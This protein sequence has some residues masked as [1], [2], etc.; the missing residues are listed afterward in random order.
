MKLVCLDSMYF[1]WGLL[2]KSSPSQSD[3]IEQAEEFLKSLDDD[4]AT[5]IVPT[6]LLQELLMDCDPSERTA[7]ITQLKSRFVLAPFDAASAQI[8]AKIW[9]EKKRAKVI[10]QIRSSGDSMRTKIKI[11]IQIIAVACSQNA[12]VLY[13]NDANLAKMAEDY[14]VTRD[15]PVFRKQLELLD[16]TPSNPQAVAP[17]P[18]IEMRRRRIE[19]N[20]PEAKDDEEDP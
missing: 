4:D 15:M 9:N 1:I 17:E 12:S 3:K 8:A 5:V 7:L 2:K 18:N 6:P 10:D 13:T 16:W 19:L 11:D 20:L 14:I